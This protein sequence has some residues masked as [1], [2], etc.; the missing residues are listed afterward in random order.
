MLSE[1]PMKIEGEDGVEE[2]G[3]V[4]EGMEDLTDNFNK[5]IRLQSKKTLVWVWVAISNS[6]HPEML[7]MGHVRKGLV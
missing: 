3:E 1:C 6:A 7:T 5:E 4:E 2:A